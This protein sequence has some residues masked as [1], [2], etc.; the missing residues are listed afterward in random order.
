L[1]LDIPEPTTSIR[2]VGD[3]KA[4]MNHVLV[5]G[6]ITEK[7]KPGWISTQ[8][9]EALYCTAVLQ[10]KTGKIV[11]NLYREQTTVE[12]G[13]NVRIVNGFTNRYG[14]LSIG[15]RGQVEVLTS[16]KKK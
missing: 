12:V 13:D 9:G 8:Y 2:L 7:S 6:K 3:L 10:D 15:K 5:E 14:E 11:M 1:K 4:G 16:K